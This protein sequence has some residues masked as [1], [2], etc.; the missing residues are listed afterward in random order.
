MTLRFKMNLNT[1]FYCK[2]FEISTAKHYISICHSTAS[3]LVSFKNLI[4]TSSFEAAI[5]L[6][7]CIYCT[8]H[9]SKHIEK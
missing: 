3:Y 6:S 8:V 4:A 2:A 7:R 5:L 1:D 9:C